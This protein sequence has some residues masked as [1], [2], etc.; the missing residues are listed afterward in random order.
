VTFGFLASPE[1]ARAESLD[2]IRVEYTAPESCPGRDAFF[3]E[4]RAR[5]PRVIFAPDGQR[6]RLFRVTLVLNE[7]GAE[8]TL[9]LTEP[10][11]P[12]SVRVVDSDTCAAVASAI[13]LVAVLAIDPSA[14][15]G[16]LPDVTSG[17]AV[18]MPVPL[19][20]G[21]TENAE[22]NGQAAKPPRGSG[23]IEEGNLAPSRLGGSPLVPTVPNRGSSEPL[24][25]EGSAS[26]GAHVLDAT[27]GAGA[28]VGPYF[29]AALARVHP[30]V[31]A[32]ELRAGLSYA[33]RTIPDPNPEN[34]GTATF[35]W[36]RG[37]VEACPLR[38][39][40]ARTVH[41]RPCASLRAGA[42]VSEGH[43]TRNS[44]TSTNPW[45]ELG[46]SALMEWDVVDPLRLEA[47]A[48][49]GFPVTRK[50]FEFQGLTADRLYTPGVVMPGGRI[51]LAVHFP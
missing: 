8:G 15:T 31:F 22:A 23:E 46:A 45:G 24:R 25:F 34:E 44:V 17:S 16:L 42:I 50:T 2:P 51:G 32:P 48:G 12:T 9:A 14:S 7:R 19:T 41:A 37:E 1:L 5:S 40:L 18:P 35:T 49:L 43:G 39:T 20:G 38:F 47:E 33:S 4:V 6:A 30:G 26:L 28:A 29:F 13:A 10:Q 11:G 36:W 3:A 21:E 27:G